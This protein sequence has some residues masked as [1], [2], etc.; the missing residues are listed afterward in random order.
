MDEVIFFIVVFFAFGV[1]GAI[2][3]FLFC[4]FLEDVKVQ[5]RIKEHIIRT[6]QNESRER[7]RY[8]ECVKHAKARG[9]VIYE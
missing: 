3:T 7:K 9:E 2:F 1:V 6:Y 5:K 4:I 8:E